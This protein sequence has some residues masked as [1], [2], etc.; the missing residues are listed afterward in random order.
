MSELSKQLL[1]WIAK[2][3]PKQEVQG[4]GALQVGKVHGGMQVVHQHFY[5]EE[6]P[7]PQNAYPEEKPATPS[8]EAKN[9][10]SPAE[11]NT[12]VSQVLTLRRQ[13][14]ERELGGFEKFM[15]K[16]FSTQYIKDVPHSELRRV[17]AYLE[18]I[19][20]NREQRQ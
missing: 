18:K 4:D 1:A 6:K 3:L 13:L 2:L 16:S 12:A 5:P 17:H 15:Q 20:Q 11:H 19:I 7:S 10:M 8:V 14:S 9:L